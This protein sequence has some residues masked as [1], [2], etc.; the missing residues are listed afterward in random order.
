M[1]MIKSR[2]IKIDGSMGE[3]GG[4]VLRT[5]L[6][7]AMLKQVKV[8]IVNIRAKRNK[9]GLLRQ[10]LTCVRAAQAICNGKVEGDELGSQRILFTPSE[11]KGGEYQFAIGTAGSTSLVCQ[12]ILLPLAL[13]ETSSQITFE[14][15]T[16]NGMSPSVS[17]LEK[18]FLPILAKMGIETEV[19]IEKLGFYPAGGGRWSLK[20]KPCAQLK[21]ME[22]VQSE[23][24]LDDITDR[25]TV[26]AIVSLLPESI[27]QREIDTVIKSLRLNSNA[28]NLQSVNTPGPGN[29][30]IIEYDHGA[31]A[32]VF[33]IVGQLGVS[34]ENVSK[35][36][37]E[38]LRKLI[39]TSANVEEHLAD[40][41]LLPMAIAGKGSFTTTEPSL[42]TKTNIN[43]IKQFGVE[44][45]S[46]EQL[47]S[48]L[49]R[50][51]TSS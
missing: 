9:P 34:A 29:T 30:V 46:T 31:Y 39:K 32:S 20:V 25:V 11:V 22:Y 2:V 38:R 24:T 50:V 48:T 12:T 47:S 27:G 19:K 14:G 8:E 5:S 1:D 4:Q 51:K 43:V 23:Q 18:S 42:H 15:G 26:T 16:H 7:L 21:P 36:A 40:Q 35:R 13:A 33:E 3:G 6:T 45:V 44:G 49:W 28:G 10:H 41:L 17:F 37:V